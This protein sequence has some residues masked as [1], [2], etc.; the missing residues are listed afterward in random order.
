MEA[1][2]V[3]NHTTHV[4]ADKARLHSDK[5][6]Q[7]YMAA[8]IRYA[9]QH[10]G[11]TAENP[12]VG[13][14][15]V[16]FDGDAPTIV[17]RGVTAIDGRPHAE[18]I[19]LQEAG[20]QARGACAYVTLEPCSHFGKTPPCANAL[21]QAG[22]T[23]VVVAVN[24]PDP[25]VAGNGFDILRTAGIEV[26]TD[27]MAQEA[28][29]GLAGYLMRKTRNRPFVTLKFAMTA[30]NFIGASNGEQVKITDKT[31]NGQVQIMRAINDAVLVGIG[32]VIND[33]PNLTCRLTGLEH[34]SPTR[35]VLDRKLQMSARSKL[36][37]TAK[38]HKLILATQSESEILAAL[39]NNDVDIVS[40]KSADNKAQLN[41]LLQHLAIN[42]ISTVLVEGG[43]QVAASFL[44]AGLVDRLVIFQSSDDLEI[45]D[46][47]LAVAAPITPQKIGSGFSLKNQLTFGSDIMYEYDRAK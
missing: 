7:K 19:A 24:D 39:V 11:L 8:A 26:V 20:A 32:T 4:T 5:I 23:R 21:I 9:R 33:D 43:A 13:A 30:D 25:R 28:E 27:V 6:D 41:E 42:D 40:L 44:N 18:V 2:G 31:S 34:R 45:Q 14:L 1:S 12:S 38:Q 37:Q 17:G 29:Y 36:V 22:V 15:I 47:K 46:R 3:Q 16:R 10:E 35:V